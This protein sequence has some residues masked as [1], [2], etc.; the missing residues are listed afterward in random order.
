MGAPATTPINE[1]KESIDRKEIALATITD[2]LFTWFDR[3]LADS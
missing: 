1:G 3:R 2:T